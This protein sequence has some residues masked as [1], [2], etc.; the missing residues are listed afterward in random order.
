M[1]IHIICI[2]I[3]KGSSRN[4]YIYTYVY[5]KGEWIDKDINRNIFANM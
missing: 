3:C 5:V 2:F 1:C 4:I